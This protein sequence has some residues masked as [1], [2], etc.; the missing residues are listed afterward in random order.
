MKLHPR[1]FIVSKAQC[2]IEQAVI[3]IAG[4]YDLSLG[5]RIGILAKLQGE[6]A[7]YLVRMERH[8][9]DDKKGDEE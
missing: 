7:K 8:G 4:R 6:T 5:E 9:R 2:E 1:Y 3:E